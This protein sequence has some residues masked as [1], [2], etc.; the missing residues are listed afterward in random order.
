MLLDFY[1]LQD[2]LAQWE[3]QYVSLSLEA[4]DR[5]SFLGREPIMLS[6]FTCEFLVGI[7]IQHFYVYPA[8]LIL[9]WKYYIILNE[10]APLSSTPHSK[11]IQSPKAAP[12]HD[13]SGATFSPDTLFTM[14]WL[15]LFHLLKYVF[16]NSKKLTSKISVLYQ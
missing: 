15:L 9:I 13:F 2:A 5:Y 10:L 3:L 6:L 7:W 11:I 8:L 1:G 4:Y 16:R 12:T 14:S